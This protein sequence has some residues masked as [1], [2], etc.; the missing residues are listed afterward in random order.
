MTRDA[1]WDIATDIRN[2][3]TSTTSEL[4]IDSVYESMSPDC[5]EPLLRYLYGQSVDDDIKHMQILTVKGL[6]DAAGDFG[7]PDLRSYVLRKLEK[8]LERALDN[9]PYFPK[10]GPPLETNRKLEPFVD[11]VQDL[12]DAEHP[13]GELGNSEVMRV[14][15]KIFCKYFAVIRQWDR[16]QALACKH[17]QL[18][19]HMLY[20]AAANGGDLL[21]TDPR[22]G[23]HVTI[24][25]FY[26]EDD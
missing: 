10:T 26:V 11:D 1:D 7:I 4:G 6:F 23:Q 2:Q 25:P 8:R 3:S 5:C 9:L 14:V 19:T 17:P 12:L 16:F 24:P 22:T 21:G 13:D 20:Y 15:V 18:H